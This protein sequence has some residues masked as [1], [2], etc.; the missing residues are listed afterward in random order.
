[1][2]ALKWGKPSNLG[3]QITAPKPA[4]THGRTIWLK[5]TVLSVESVSLA[6]QRNQTE[7]L[8]A[9]TMKLLLSKQRKQTLVRCSCACLMTARLDLGPHHAFPGLHVKTI[10]PRVG[11]VPH[12]SG[13][14]RFQVNSPLVRRMSSLGWLCGYSVKPGAHGLLVKPSYF[15]IQLI[16]EIRKKDAPNLA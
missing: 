8:P 4:K 11:E 16:N 1:M 2:K 15:L 6:Y 7:V 9:T 14:P 10:I 3:N 13:F 12:L 5:L